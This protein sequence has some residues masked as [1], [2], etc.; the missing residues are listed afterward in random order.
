MDA[1]EI[2]KRQR[3]LKRI[4]ANISSDK[5]KLVEDLIQNAAFMEC[6]LIELQAEIR[7]N[8]PVTTSVNGNGF[9]VTSESAAQKSYNTTINRYSS[10]I[11]QLTELLPDSKQDAVNRAGDSLAAFVLRGK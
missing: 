2:K 7:E 4:F 6:T 5:K 11:K 1:E 9:E 10:I 8:G 3:R